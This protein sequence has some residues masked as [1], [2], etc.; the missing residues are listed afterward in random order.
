MVDNP[1]LCFGV[2]INVCMYIQVRFV[3]YEQRTAGSNWVEYTFYFVSDHPQASVLSLSR[4][5]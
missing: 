3:G 5:T 2:L 1:P 4:K